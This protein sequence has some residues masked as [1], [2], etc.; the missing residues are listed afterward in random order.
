LRVRFEERFLTAGDNLW[1]FFAGHGKRYKGRDYLMPIDG[2]PSNVE[3]T[4]ISIRDISDRLRRSGADNIILLVDACRG[5]DDR[6][7]GEG[8]GREK[9]QGV[10][11]LFSCSPNEL[12]YE[13][14]QLQQGTFTYALLEGLRLQGE[15][16]CATVERLDQ[17]LRHYVPQINQRYRKPEQTPYAMVEPAAKYHLIL[18]PRAATVKDA[19]TLKLEAYKAEAQRDYELAEQFWV[20]VLAVSPADPDAIQAIRR[21]ADPNREPSKASRAPSSGSARG[22]VAPTFSIG[23]PEISRRKT[24][25]ILVSGAA[26]GFGV[27]AIS[28]IVP[29]SSTNPQ[30]ADSTNPQRAEFKVVTVDA[31]GEIVKTE[32][33]Q[34]DVFKADLGNGILLAMVRT[35]LGSNQADGAKLLE[36]RM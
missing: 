34:T 24:L 7:G 32:N 4:A 30:R 28:K 35:E 31:K 13:I 2:D 12:S 5:E 36:V 25:Q 19:E 15:G 18:L 11:T 33:R 14:D 10:V 21:L 16:N 3:R 1:F 20:R 22:G 23:R 26:G 8:I 17:Y 27:W 9:Q 29:S 6:D